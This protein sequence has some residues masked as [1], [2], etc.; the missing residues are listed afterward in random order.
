MQV[1][2]AAGLFCSRDLNLGE[3]EEIVG[4]VVGIFLYNEK[5]GVSSSGSSP[6]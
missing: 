1:F 2:S 6:G 5:Q 4:K 3:A